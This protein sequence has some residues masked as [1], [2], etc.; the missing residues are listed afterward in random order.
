MA[1][2]GYPIVSSPSRKR[3]GKNRRPVE[4]IRVGTD[5]ARG[6]VLARFATTERGPGYCHLPDGRGYDHERFR[7]FT[8]MKSILH[9][10]RG[11]GKRVWYLLSGR[12]KEAF[13]CRV[14]A[15]AALNI[16]DPDWATWKRRRRRQAERTEQQDADAHPSDAS[17][18]PVKAV[19]KKRSTRR[20]GSSWV[21]SWR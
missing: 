2:S 20:P 11:I 16:L 13:D 6:I 17:S 4:L 8:S 19:Q 21:N 14:Y 10:S 7:Q 12:R 1:G 5:Q 18:A 3:T 9:Y 15:Y